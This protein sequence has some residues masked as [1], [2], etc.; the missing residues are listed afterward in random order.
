MARRETDPFASFNFLVETGGVLQAGFSEV[1]GL[2][3]ETEMIEYRNGNEDFTPRKLPGRKKF[4]NVTLKR[5][6]ALGQDFLTWRKKVTDGKIDRQNVSI[7]VL[8]ESR[9]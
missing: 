9:K 7:I 3:S 6:L 8:D 1:T 2:N 4:G 5:G